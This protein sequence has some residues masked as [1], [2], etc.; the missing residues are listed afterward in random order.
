M[1][2]YFKK[3]VAQTLR[4]TLNDVCLN[5]SFGSPTKKAGTMRE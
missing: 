3:S 2:N 5:L 1:Y 4:V